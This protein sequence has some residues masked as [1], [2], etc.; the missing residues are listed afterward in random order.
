MW[1][2]D[3]IEN[4]DLVE[5]I[6]KGMFFQSPFQGE[7]TDFVVI[8]DGVL[9]ED[10]ARNS[11]EELFSDWQSLW[12]K[13]LDKLGV[14]DEITSHIEGKIV[15]FLDEYFHYEKNFNGALQ[16]VGYDAVEELSFLFNNMQGDLCRLLECEAVGKASFFTNLVKKAYLLGGFPC[17]WSDFYPNGKLVV[18]SNE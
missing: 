18:F 5:F 9:A 11:D 6:K 1:S 17:G 15:D 14:Y 10:Y 13:E 3:K 2:I 12:D 4:Q 8:T 16:K 7:S